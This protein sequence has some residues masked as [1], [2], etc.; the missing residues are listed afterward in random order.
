MRDNKSS[1]PTQIGLPTGVFCGSRGLAKGCL[2][3]G[4]LFSAAQREAGG[5]PGLLVPSSSQMRLWPGAR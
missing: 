1:T 3:G 5:E 4:S 2:Q